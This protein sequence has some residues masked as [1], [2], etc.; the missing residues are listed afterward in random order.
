MCMEGSFEK[1]DKY[2]SPNSLLEENRNKFDYSSVYLVPAL[3]IDSFMVKEELTA[4][5]VTSAFCAK[6]SSPPDICRVY[7]NMVHWNRHNSDSIIKFLKDMF[8]MLFF[9]F[10]IFLVVLLIIKI[11]FKKE[12]NT[13][14]RNHIK[15]HVS[16]YMKITG[17]GEKI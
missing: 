12:M 3:F 2:K 7:A 6:L 1:G 11:S 15:E 17:E 13:G 10:L 9:V 4:P 5:L 8:K 16:Q 14:M